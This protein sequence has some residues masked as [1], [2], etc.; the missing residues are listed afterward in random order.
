MAGEVIGPAKEEAL[1]R[2]SLL[3]APSYTENFGMVV[4]EGLAHGVPAIAGKGM[5]WQKMEE[6]GCGLWVENDPATLAA[7]IQALSRSDLNAMGEA[8]RRWMEREFSWDAIAKR[9]IDLYRSKLPGSS[10][11]EAAGARI[12]GASASSWGLQSNS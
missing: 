9:M 8:G 1:A 2:A 5:P 12:H 7:S 6:V 10:A 11:R 3:V 4:A